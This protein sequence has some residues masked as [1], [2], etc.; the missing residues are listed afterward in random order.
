MR[1]QIGLVLTGLILVAVWTGY[2][3]TH[4]SA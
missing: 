3:I 1:F 2:R 4:P